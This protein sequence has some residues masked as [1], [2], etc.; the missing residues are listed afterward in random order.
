[1]LLKTGLVLQGHI[2]KHA[3]LTLQVQEEDRDQDGKPDLLMLQIN[4]PLQPE[5]QM[6]GVQLLLTFSY[7]LFVCIQCT[8]TLPQIKRLA[9]ECLYLSVSVQRMSTL[10]MQTLAFVQHSSPV[11]GSQLFVCGDLKLNQ[12]APLAHRGVH[13]MYNVSISMSYTQSNVMID[14]VLETALTSIYVHEIPY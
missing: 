1:M 3:S 4:I 9:V 12:R 14:S 10:V 11:P 6:F 7:Q 5:E 2:L 13:S 8:P